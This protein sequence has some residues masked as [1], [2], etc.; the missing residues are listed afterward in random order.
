M[1]AKATLAWGDSGKEAQTRVQLMNTQMEAVTLQE[2]CIYHHKFDA[3]TET[4]SWSEPAVLQCYKQGLPSIISS[5]L[6][7][8]GVGETINAAQAFVT[9]T[10]GEMESSESMKSI[11]KRKIM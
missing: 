7:K 8:A 9:K 3:L 11:D 5:Q 6:E 2:L 4:I 1:V 10:V